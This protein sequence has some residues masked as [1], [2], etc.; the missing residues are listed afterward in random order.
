MIGSLFRLAMDAD[1]YDQLSTTVTRPAEQ[2]TQADG[3]PDA[4]QLRAVDG[5]D[6][7]DPLIFDQNY[8]PKPAYFA[9]MDDLEKHV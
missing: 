5:K 8:R 9:L 1:L 6:V 2:D 4:F 7:P 3:N